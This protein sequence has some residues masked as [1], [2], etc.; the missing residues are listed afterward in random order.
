MS[1]DRKNVNEESLQEAN[2]G[3]HTSLYG[4]HAFTYYVNERRT[5]V[6]YITWFEGE[7]VKYELRDL[8]NGQIDLTSI[9]YRENNFDSFARE[10]P[11]RFE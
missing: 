10:F 3:S 6:A 1:E 8:V 4:R 11:E 2:G 7:T 9:G 5:Q